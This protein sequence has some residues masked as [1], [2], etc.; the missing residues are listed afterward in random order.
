MIK[1]ALIDD[2]LGYKSIKLD[3]CYSEF[4]VKKSRI[5]SYHSKKQN[6]NS[7]GLICAKLISVCNSDCIEMISYKIKDESKKGNVSDLVAAINDSV[8][9]N[10]DLIHMSVGS[11]SSED[12]EAISTAVKC[13]LNRNICIIAAGD[14]NDEKTYPASIEGVIGVRHKFSLLCQKPH[15]VLHDPFG[16]NVEICSPNVIEGTDGKP[17]PIKYCNSFAAAKVSSL[18]LTAMITGK[19]DKSANML[20]LFSN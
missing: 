4:I 17:F 20:I 9:R 8:K 7:H 11:T 6:K 19:A 13:A 2:G 12:F 15:I 14:N 16:I 1:V 3:C 18:V 10:V 5:I